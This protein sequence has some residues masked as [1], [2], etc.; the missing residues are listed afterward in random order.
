MAKSG[1]KSSGNNITDVL[2]FIAVVFGG[3]ALFAAMILGK[4]DIQIGLVSIIQKVANIIGWAVLCALSFN[5]IKN[6]RRV[7]MWVI[8]AIA[9]VM[10]IVGII[11]A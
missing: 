4:L 9:F 7:W 11:L 10:I 8:W 2:G 6:K 5:F 1:N 3:I